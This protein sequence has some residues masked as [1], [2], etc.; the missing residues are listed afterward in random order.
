MMTSVSNPNEYQRRVVTR[1]RTARGHLDG[2]IRMVEA[3]AYCPEV[4]KQLSAVQ[5]LL[6]GTSRG[7]LRNHLE[8]C[9]AQAMREGR[10]EEIVDEL[11]EALKYDKRALRPV[12]ADDD[13]E[14][15][16][17]GET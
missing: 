6:E 9:V 12:A 7:V 3:G 1:L 5:G 2:V 8:T 14:E 4:M 10:V 13:L 11:M 16:V 17:G 15:S